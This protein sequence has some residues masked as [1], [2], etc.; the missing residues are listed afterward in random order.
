MPK[1]ATRL[2][3]ITNCIYRRDAVSTASRATSIVISPSGGTSSDRTLAAA[4][5]LGELPAAADL[6][7]GPR[8]RPLPNKTLW[9]CLFGFCNTCP[10]SHQVDQAAAAPHLP[11]SE[12]KCC[13]IHFVLQII[14]MIGRSVPTD[15]RASGHQNY[16][17]GGCPLA[18]L[19]YAI[20]HPLGW[21][22]GAGR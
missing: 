1:A 15:D 16:D 10:A 17:E 20:S 4:S 19:Q 21:R 22:G 7:Q 14:D 2:C 5:N 3:R 12:R 13:S 6:C 11:E 9:V 8:H 18:G